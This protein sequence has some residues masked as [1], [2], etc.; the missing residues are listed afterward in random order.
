MAG[1]Q[2]NALTSIASLNVP[3]ELDSST[4]PISWRRN[5]GLIYPL[6]ND[7]WVMEVGCK[8]KWLSKG[9]PTLNQY[10]ISPLSPHQSIGKISTET[11]LQ[12]QI[13]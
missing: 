3:Y 8:T 2:W 6:S 12:T 11:L 1:S 13:S 7:H 5:W 9:P 4:G 10:A